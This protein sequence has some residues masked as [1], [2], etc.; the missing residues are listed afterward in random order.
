M[1]WS[2]GRRDA[3]AGALVRHDPRGYGGRVPLCAGNRAT[4]DQGLT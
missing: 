1:S 3:D 2:A 4:T